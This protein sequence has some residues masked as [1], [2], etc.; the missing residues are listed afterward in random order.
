MI[1]NKLKMNSSKTVFVVFIS[2][3]LKCDLSRLSM[4]VKV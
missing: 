4:L 1:T 2:P 3:Q